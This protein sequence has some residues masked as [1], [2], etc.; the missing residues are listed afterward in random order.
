MQDLACHGSGQ[1]AVHT[2]WGNKAKL[3]VNIVGK[4]E[5]GEGII[6]GNLIQF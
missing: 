5:A 3:K 4:G 1:G 6:K 2:R